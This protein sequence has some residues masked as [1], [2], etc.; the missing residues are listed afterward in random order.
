[1]IRI[2]LEK[3]NSKSGNGPRDLVGLNKMKK[4]SWP[5]CITAR[6]CKEEAEPAERNSVGA[7]V[8]CVSSLSWMD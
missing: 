1:M 6:R 3:T 8:E 5:K 7:Q 4:A 2:D